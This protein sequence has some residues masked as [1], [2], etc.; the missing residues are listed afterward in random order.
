MA[1]ALAVALKGVLTVPSCGPGESGR[2]G[3]GCLSS[4]CLPRLEGE[5]HGN[6]V[7]LW[8]ILCFSG[9]SQVHQ[10][11]SKTVPPACEPGKPESLPTLCSVFHPLETARAGGGFLGPGEWGAAPA[12]CLQSPAWSLPR[13]LQAG[14]A[15]SGGASAQGGVGGPGDIPVG[16]ICLRQSR[17]A[18]YPPLVLKFPVSSLQ[19]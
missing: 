15:A 9:L 12:A 7:G 13:V 19:N 17:Q 4:P 10:T 8:G 1:C 16:V 18:R 3:A 6:P 11:P 2:S 14:V 5:G